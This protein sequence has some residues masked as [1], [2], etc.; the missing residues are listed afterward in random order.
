[1]HIAYADLTDTG[2]ILKS[3]N[4][5]LSII[6]HAQ[7]RYMDTNISVVSFIYQQSEVFHEDVNTLVNR[8][9]AREQINYNTTSMVSRI[10]IQ[11]NSK[12]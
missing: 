10:K 12:L 4:T 8:V 2:I 6:L 11:L 7:I 1:M 5:F 9:F 3:L